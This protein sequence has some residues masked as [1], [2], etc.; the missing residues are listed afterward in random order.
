MDKKVIIFIKTIN[1]NIIL[2]DERIKI[3]E[4]MKNNRIFEMN[5]EMIFGVV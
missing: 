2:D 1:K 5:L 4:M 3:I